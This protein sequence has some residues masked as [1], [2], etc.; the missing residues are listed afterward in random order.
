MKVKKKMKE[1]RDGLVQIRVSDSEQNRLDELCKVTGLD[2]SALIRLV[3][4][5]MTDGQIKKIAAGQ[6]AITGNGRVLWD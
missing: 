6:Y 2:M 5:G 3:V 4:L 1:T